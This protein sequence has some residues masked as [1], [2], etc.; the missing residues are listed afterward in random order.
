[1]EMAEGGTGNGGN[2]RSDVGMTSEK[3]GAQRD[4][5]SREQTSNQAYSLN[6]Q[7]S[8][9]NEKKGGKETRGGLEVY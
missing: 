6:E 8:W 1:M 9:G 3:K 5:P 4:L 7:R 2:G